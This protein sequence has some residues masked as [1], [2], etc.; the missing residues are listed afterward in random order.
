M[1]SSTKC[2]SQRSKITH[3]EIIPRQNNS[4]ANQHSRM[5]NSKIVLFIQMQLCDTTLHHWLRYRDQI[6][7]DEPSTEKNKNFHILN[8]LGRSQCWNI[9]H[10]LL[11]AVE[12]N[13]IQSFERLFS[14]CFSI[15][16]L[17]HS[18]IEISNH[19]IFFL[20]TIP[21]IVRLFMSNSVILV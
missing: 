12:V 15:F 10:Q 9:F 17:S 6:L 13:F 2:V 19:E 5:N 8:D 16:I 4:Y 7:I 14:D 3:Q 11:T 1:P 18:S 20:L 21:K